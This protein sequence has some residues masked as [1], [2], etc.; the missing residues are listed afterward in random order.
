M[1]RP[2]DEFILAWGSLSGSS[3]EEGWRSIPVTPA[4]LCV[5][6]AGRRFPGNEESLLAGFTSVR[7]PAAE[8]L[9]EGRGFTVERV[10][11]RGDGKIWLAL[12]R[13]ESGSVEL[14]ATMVCDVTGAM[15]AEAASGE[16][17]LLRVFLGRVSAW[18][19]FMRK[20]AQALSPEAEI[21]LI[22]E[23]SFLGAIIEAGIPAPLA[24]EAWVG[25]LNGIQDFEIGTGAVEVKAT[26]STASFPAKIGSLEQ[27]DDSVRQP[28]FV[29]GARLSQTESGQNLPEFIEAVRRVLKGDT[30]AERL[31]AE[32]LLAAGYF[33]AHADRYPRRFV[34]AGTKVIEVADGFPRITP[35]TA[36]DGIKRVI[37]EI[38][39]DK[40]PGE[41]LD[42]EDAL[43]RLGAL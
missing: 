8:K 17:R 25:P 19:E 41:V 9:P 3:G 34:L 20:G 37:Y 39:L 30:E 24:V 29:A 21:G 32:R 35:G 31:F 42:P 10:D 22:G 28:L 2:I 16:E 4:G 15:D 5:L 40:A 43:K 12:T 13:R 6:Q 36:P 11:P 1:A 23:L 18:Q 26:V 27:L 33:D 7:I 38:D 14:F